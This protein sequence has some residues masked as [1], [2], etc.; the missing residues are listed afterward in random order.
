MPPILSQ[1]EPSVTPDSQIE[2][3][4]GVNLG[5]MLEAPN[6]G[7]WGL[8]VK[9]EYFDRIKDA[10][11]DFVR[12]PVRWNAHA[13]QE[14][15]YNIDPVFFDRIDK[16]V[17]WALDR[18]LVI[19]LNIHHYE[20]IMQDPEGNKARYLGIWHQLAEHY[21]NA[22]P[23]VLFELLNEPF[24]QLD[25]P[26]WNEY[27][28]EAL[29]VVRETNPER[30]VIVGPVSWNAYDQLSRLEL[31]SDEHLIVTFHYYLPFHF[32][33]Q[34]AEWVDGSTAWMG[35]TWNATEAE[36]SEI[37]DHFD[38]VVHWAKEHNIRVLLGE[39]GAFYKAPIDSRVRWTDFVRSEAERHGFAWAYWE[40]ASNFG[41]YNPHARVWRKDLLN[42]LIPR[43]E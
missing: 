33:H 4:R 6:E 18:D 15:P 34:G 28:A 31:P 14:P 21:K 26:L 9:E 2:L 30:E 10:G 5:N 24:D 37:T 13:T 27:L 32:T 36:K 42:A 20:E 1:H 29:A 16:I 23:G 11:F 43:E 40:F 41:V 17:N 25:P 8:T 3:Q 19:L 7:D 38:S 39:F 22:P 35:T 12:L